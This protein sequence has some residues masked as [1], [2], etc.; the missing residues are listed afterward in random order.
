MKAVI[1]AGGMGV[2]FLPA[3]K[4]QPKEM[5][6]IVDKPS[7]HYVVEEAIKADIRTIMIITGRG[8]KSI[9]DYFD[10]NIELEHYYK[11]P[12]N[13]DLKEIKSLL[14]SASFYYARQNEP[15]GLGHAILCAKDFVGNESF[16]VMLG[17]D[18]FL[19]ECC[20]QTLKGL[21]EEKSTTFVAVEE[22]TPDRISQYGVIDAEEIDDGIYR[23]KDMVEKPTPEDA[24]SNL[25]MVGRYVFTPR[26]FSCLERIN[27]GMNNEYQLTDAMK[28]LNDKEDVLAYKVKGRRLDIGSKI[29]WMKATIELALRREEFRDDLKEY[30]ASIR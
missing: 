24:P 30:L 20:I 1:P 29:G 22:V 27:P 5:L 2:R 7:L 6:P 12:N 11:N 14:N 19:D 17:D 13:P 23:V 26:I 8:K 4:A 25:A 10:K 21:H 9:E 15:L 18:I 28:L 3:T 16:A